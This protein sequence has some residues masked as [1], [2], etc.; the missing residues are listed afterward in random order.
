[1]STDPRSRFRVRPAIRRLA[2]VALVV[3]TPVAAGKIWDHVELRRL[4]QEIE[5]IQASGQPVTL[6][7]AAARSASPDARERGAGPY[8]LA[9]GLISSSI[10]SE[11]YSIGGL[12][13]VRNWIAGATGTPPPFA[14]TANELR[15]AAEGASDALALAD[16]AAPLP[17][18]GFPPG[19]EYGYRAQSLAQVSLAMS[20][21][22]LSL[23]LDGDGDRAVESALSALQFRRSLRDILPRLG[24]HET[25]AILSFSTP[26]TAQL[27]RLQDALQDAEDSDGPLESLLESRARYVEQI[28]RRY[29]GSTPSAPPIYSLPGRSVGETIS[30]PWVSRRVVHTLR[31]WADV[32]DAARTPWPAKRQAAEDVLR[33]YETEINRGASPQWLTL[34]DGMPVVVWWG[35]AIPLEQLRRTVAVP[36]LH[37]LGQMIVDRSARVAI[38]IERYRRDHRDAL[39]ETLE[40]LVPEQLRDIPADP[41]TGASLLYRVEPDA[42]VVYS[43]GADLADDG[44][45]LLEPAPVGSAQPFRPGPDVGVR[46]LTR[47]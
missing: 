45:A 42:Y 26:S 10:G 19:T 22:T 3:L 11:S 33:R 2:L 9:A 39:P 28:W 8:Y 1:M 24:D 32:I 31:I 30:R 29:Y 15:T 44:G 41:L 18:V 4:I 47:R 43:V 37:G 14:E 16:A 34:P 36:G 12:L 27:V 25:A 5:R 17:F 7:E 23:S 20:A 46:V 21:R 13:G 40:A 35:A 38:A 6:R